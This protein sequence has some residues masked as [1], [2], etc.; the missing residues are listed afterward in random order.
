MFDLEHKLLAKMLDPREIQRIHDLGLREPAFEDL[1]CRAAFGWM[2]EYWETN[3]MILAPTDVVMKYEFPALELPEEVDEA[4]EWI[5][6][7]LQQR[8]ITNRVQAAMFDAAKDLNI[9]PE[10]TTSA[11]WQTLYDISESV[12]PRTSRSDMSNVEERDRRY[13]ARA[14]AIVGG[15]PYGLQRGNGTPDSVPTLDDQTH[16]QLPGEL[17]VVAAFTKVGKSFMLCKSI[18]EA[19]MAGLRPVMFT[20]EMSIKEM[21]DRIDA[22]YSGVSYA[23]LTEGSMMPSDLDR[24]REARAQLAEIGPLHIE[25]PHR[26]ERTVKHMVNRARQLG[27]DYLL[28]DQLSFIDAAPN[29]SYGNDNSGMRMKHGDIT[30]ELKDE[31]A[32]ES[33]GALPCM[34][35]VQL[36][37]DAM[38]GGD[39]RGAL[40]NLANS[41]FIEQTADI[42]LGLWRND[43]MRNSNLMGMDILGSRRCDKMSWLLNWRL[44]D[45][46]QVSIQRE[47]ED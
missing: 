1:T 42:V 2:V 21:E 5:V 6:S 38:R 43:D 47:Y 7:A 28:I 46:T 32:R 27:S 3:S 8:H 34:L 23:Q 22:F 15:V 16:G 14:D 26:G 17:A 9:D 37:R 33:A 35:A 31:I 10:A 24:L 4:T 39:G 18:A 20:L 29:R 12:V 13:L 44:H 36:N 40:H 19:H 30:F 25:R 11:L 45:R 41:S